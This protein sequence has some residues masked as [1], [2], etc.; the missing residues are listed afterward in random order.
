MKEI[1]LKGSLRTTARKSDIKKLRLEEK[2]PCILYG[3]GIEN[4]V[5]FAIEAKELKN[6]THTPA[7]YIINL[8]IDGKV[9]KAI[10]H[11]I[12]YHP[13]T[14][15]A[16]HVD[17]LAVSA[18]KPV[19]IEIPVDIFGNSEG[20]KQGGKLMV[21]TRKLRVCGELD[22]LPDTLPVDITELKLGKQ[23]TAGDLSFDG[24]QIVSP[25]GTIICA[26]KM[27][28]AALGAAAAAAAAAKKA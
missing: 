5:M 9:Y 24:I 28:R 2:V 25:K 15:E 23:I 26:V 4:N 6:V 13:V 20:V 27:T 7:S 18:E 1:T 14:D 12:Q 11:Q 17:F 16:L 21:S 19:T 8:D 22:K 10:F 3:H